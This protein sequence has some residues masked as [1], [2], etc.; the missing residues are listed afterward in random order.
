MGDARVAVRLCSLFVAPFSLRR[1]RQTLDKARCWTFWRDAIN[2]GRICDA[3][4]LKDGFRRVTRDVI[5]DRVTLVAAGV[6]FYVLLSLF[7][8]LGAALSF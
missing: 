5:G 1:S 3:I 2:I 6:A 4:A 7:P 8:T